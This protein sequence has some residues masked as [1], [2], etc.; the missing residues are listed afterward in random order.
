MSTSLA[1]DQQ[2]Q[3]LEALQVN[4]KVRRIETRIGPDSLAVLAPTDGEQVD[5][6]T[7]SP[8]VIDAE[9]LWF[10]DCTGE[11]IAE[12]HD[13]TGAAVVIAGNLARGGHHV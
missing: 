12:A 13:V 8:R 11:A 5:T 2:R 4:L 9:R 1:Q 10:F 6:I 7:C 3:A